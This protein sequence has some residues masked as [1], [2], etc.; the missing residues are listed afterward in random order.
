MNKAQHL[1][2]LAPALVL[3]VTALVPARSH[4]DS[5]LDGP[6]GVAVDPHGDV[7]VADRGHSR[8]VE[9]APSGRLIRSW[10]AGGSDFVLGSPT[11]VATDARGNVYVTDDENDSV[12]KYTFDG[13]LL[14]QWGTSGDGEFSGPRS[15]AVSK[16]GDVFVANTENNN[17]EKLSA[18]GYVL[19]TW[20]VMGQDGTGPYKAL[21]VAVDRAGTVYSTIER[22]SMSCNCKDPQSY[23]SYSIQKHSASGALLAEW[24]GFGELSGIAIGGRGNVFALDASRGQIIKLSPSG[25]ILNTW[26]SP[27]DGMAQFDN[28]SGITI[29]ARGAIYVADTGNN[30]VVRLSSSGDVLSVLG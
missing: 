1:R 14:A 30:R 8:I 11:D 5:T 15:V 24:T 3:A 21:A 27:G 6:A 20:S 12:Q 17:L 2:Y 13:R 9:F 23:T 22:S 4:A 7:Y 16:H 10:D 25:E 26:G 29:D 28:P 18:D 19:D